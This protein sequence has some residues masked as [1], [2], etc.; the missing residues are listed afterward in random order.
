MANAEVIMSLFMVIPPFAWN[1]FL[2]PESLT[3]QQILKISMDISVSEIHQ[4]FQ[5]L[6]R[7]DRLV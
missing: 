5:L 3:I 1:Y 4:K 2:H 6:L 7:V